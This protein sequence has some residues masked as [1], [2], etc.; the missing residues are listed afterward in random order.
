MYTVSAAMRFGMGLHKQ[1]P[2]AER[3]DKSII[4]LASLAG[5]SGTPGLC[6]YTASKWG[7]RGL[8]RS[9]LDDAQVSSSPVRFNLIAPYFVATPLI[10][11]QVPLLESMGIKLADID[12]VEAAAMRFMCDKSIYSRAAGIWQGGAVDLGD[13]LGG[14]DG[15]TAMTEGVESGALRRAGG[16]IAKRRV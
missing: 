6:D 7:V 4:M 16:T 14:G 13:D 2:I 10:E 9:L 5:Y 1:E 8:Q 15:A 3:T 12:D 11:D